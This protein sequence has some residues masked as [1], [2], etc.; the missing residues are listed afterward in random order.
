M[1]YDL[2]YMQEHCIDVFFKYGNKPFHVLT[3]GTV[4]PLALNNVETNRSLQHQIAVDVSGLQIPR[5]VHIE[6]EYVTTIRRDSIQA[7]GEYA[8]DEELPP[9]E[10]V[11]VQM[12]KPMAELGFYSYDCIEELDDRMGLYRLVAYPEGVIMAPEYK[13]LPEFAG[14]DVV[15]QDENRGVIISFKM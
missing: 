8:G 11:V 2:E 15:E 14:I 13:D 12:F 9:N 3:Y 6:Q 5:E 10:N 1:E 4:I 7:S